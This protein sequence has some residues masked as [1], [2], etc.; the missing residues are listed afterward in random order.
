MSKVVFGMCTLNVAMLLLTSSSLQWEMSPTTWGRKEQLIDV[1]K[2]VGQVVGFR[3]VFD[4]ETG[5]PRGY[6][7]CEFADHETAASAVRNLNNADVGGRPLR[8]DLA[9]SDPF[10]EGKTTV[11]GELLD[12][13]DPRGRW[14]DHREHQDRDRDRFDNP[15]DQPKSQESNSFLSSLPPGVPIVPGST[16]LDTISQTLATM[17]PAQLVEVL[18]QMKA[19]VITHPDQARALLVAHPQYAYALFQ[20]LLLNKIV[21]QS[22]LQRMLQA[23][24]GSGAPP[25]PGIS[26]QPH[27]PMQQYQQPPPMHQPQ[28]HMP[29]PMSAPPPASTA[30]PSI[31]PHQQPPLTPD[32]INGLPPSEREA[33]QNLRNQFLGGISA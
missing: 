18:A 5:K 6:G 13:S 32:Q 23:T 3:L 7:F 11:R 15:R 30:P 22:V 9:D 2:S 24:A 21:D 1:F 4:R 28:P 29:P 25:G 26:Q 16:A 12:G 19:F 10:L 14:R 17:S 33:I 27:H 8:I 20:A 31:Y